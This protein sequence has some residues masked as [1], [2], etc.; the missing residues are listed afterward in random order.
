MLI[1]G[2]LMC[3]WYDFGLTLTKLESI[4]KTGEVLSQIINKVEVIKQ[5]FEVKRFVL[6]LSALI[7]NSDMP[8]AVK[9]NY[10]NIIKALIYLSDKSIKIRGE[11]RQKPEE[12]EVEHEA[13][14]QIIEDEEDDIGVDIESDEDEDDWGLSDEEDVDGDDQLYDSPL[15]KIDEVIHFHQQLAK[16]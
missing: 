5:D 13:P 7:V 8:Q 16:L 14:G 10:S 11:E 3:F 1:Q 4:G 12:A 6:G 15:D 2:V 9:D